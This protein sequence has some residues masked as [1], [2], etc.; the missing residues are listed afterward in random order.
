[1]PILDG[2]ILLSFTGSIFDLHWGDW[3]G[4]S[5]S[6]GQLSH[7]LFHQGTLELR[8]RNHVLCPGLWR[9]PKCLKLKCMADTSVYCLSACSHHLQLKTLP[10]MYCKEF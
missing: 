8:H 3:S 9:D 7:S 1:M 2:L 4:Q 5:C 6:P 10:E